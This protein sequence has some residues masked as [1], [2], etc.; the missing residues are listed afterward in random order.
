M[1]P[2]KARADDA[3]KPE[4]KTILVVDDE[5]LVRMVIAE[6]L[7]D[8]GYL[9]V[10]AASADE[11]AAILRAG[12]DVD[13][14]FTDVT[15]PG[16]LDGLALAELVRANYP[17]LK[18]VITSGHLPPGDDRRAGADAFLPKPYLVGSAADRIG[19]ILAGPDE[20]TP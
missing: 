19:G 4:R 2:R 7:R 17:S 12:M 9:V 10:E 16:R 5:V 13:L 3:P 8:R 14:V 1:A 11:A 15:M 18:V 20:R 6:E